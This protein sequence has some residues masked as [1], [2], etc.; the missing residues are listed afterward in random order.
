MNILNGIDFELP[1]DIGC[2]WKLHQFSLVAAYS[3]QCSVVS[4]ELGNMELLIHQFSDN[5][6]HFE[7][8]FEKYWFEN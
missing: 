4:M 7:S 2:I 1:E 6:F 8:F 3:Q 5:N